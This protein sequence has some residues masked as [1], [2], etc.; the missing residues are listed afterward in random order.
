VNAARGMSLLLRLAQYWQSYMHTF[1]IRIFKSETQRPSAA[2]EWQM[3]QDDALPIP[4]A[5][6]L[7]STPLEVQAAS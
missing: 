3:P 5:L 7:R 4:S 1:V 6:L 2:N